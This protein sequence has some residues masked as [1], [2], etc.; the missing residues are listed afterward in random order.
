[1]PTGERGIPV[2][3]M[4]EHFL[5]YLCIK[6][7]FFTNLGKGSCYLVACSCSGPLYDNGCYT[8]FHFLMHLHLWLSQVPGLQLHLLTDNHVFQGD[9]LLA[10][11]F[12]VTMGWTSHPSTGIG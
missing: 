2:Q 11:S 3:C 6:K 7:F 10:A 12:S 4:G 8:Q 5:G 9:Y 1:M